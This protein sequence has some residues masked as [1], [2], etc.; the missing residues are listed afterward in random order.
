MSTRNSPRLQARPLR[1]ASACTFTRAERLS[2]RS[3][4]TLSRLKSTGWRSAPSSSPSTTHPAVRT[5]RVRPRTALPLN[6]SPHWKHV[7]KVEKLPFSPHSVHLRSRP[8]ANSRGRDPTPPPGLAF[9]VIT[10]ALSHS[11]HRPAPSLPLPPPEQGSPRQVVVAWGR[12]ADFA[13]LRRGAEA[14]EA[15]VSNR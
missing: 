13:P 1:P 10:S 9:S 5:T 11:S 2:P 15:E 4:T 7:P 3:D 6:H 14:E 12:K 8:P